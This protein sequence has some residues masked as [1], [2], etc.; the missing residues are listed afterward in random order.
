MSVRGRLTLWYTAVVAVVL[1]AFSSMSYALLAREIRAATDA[2]L[3]DTAREFAAAV[4]RDPLTAA[5]PNG[6]PLDFRFSDRAILVYSATGSVVVSSRLPLSP[7]EQRQLAEAVR[8]GFRGFITI[9]G[10]PE[11]D[12]IRLFGLPATVMGQRYL[13]VVAHALDEQTNRLD[14]AAEAVLLGIPLALLLAAGGGYL[15]ARKALRPVTAMSR[16]ARQIGAETLAARIPVENEGDE[17]GFLALTLNDLL[18]RLQSSFESQRRFMAD[19]SHELRTPVAVI[20]GEADVTLSRDDRTLDDYRESVQVVQ[21]AALKLTRIVQNLFLLARTDAGGYPMRKSGFYL[22]E[23]I[24]D[25]VRALRNIAAARRVTLRHE[26]ETDM[27]LVADEELIHRMLLNLID[28]ALKFTPAG[29]RVVVRATRESGSYA[30]RVSDSGPGIAPDDQPRVFQRFF[31]ADRARQ[32]QD[33]ASDASSGAGLGLPIA[34][35]IAEAHGGRLT[36]ERSDPGGTTFL[37][38]LPV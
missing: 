28:N 30:I 25:C 36:I 4:A 14:N 11:D 21:K 23:V 32:P 19:A 18:G 29:G 20:Q 37:V 38:T 5:S 15:L 3:E 26:A 8:R 2:S 31:R 6:V 22:D 7:A 33:V 16:Q 27:R 17:L 1:V 12:G 24:A 10:G 13:I 34:Q 35:W 9:P